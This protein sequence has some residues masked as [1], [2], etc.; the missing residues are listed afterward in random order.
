MNWLMDRLDGMGREKC[1][2]HIDANVDNYL[3]LENGEVK[4][5]DWEYAGMCDPAIDVAMCAIYSYY[6]ETQMEHLLKLYLKQGTH[7]GGAVCDLRVR[8]PGRFFV[9][10]VGGLQ[11]RAGRRVWGIHHHHVSL[12]EKILSEITEIV[13]KMLPFSMTACAIIRNM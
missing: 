13:I 7:E 5:L 11:E 12:R 2:S 3:F 1:L 9:E 4:L 6:D 10:S 8:G